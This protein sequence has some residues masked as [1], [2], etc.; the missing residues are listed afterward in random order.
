MT[1]LSSDEPEP[2]QKTLLLLLLDQ[3]LLPLHPLLH[4][5]PLLYGHVEFLQDQLLHHLGLDLR[6]PLHPHYDEMGAAHSLRPLRLLRPLF[7]LLPCP[8]QD[9]LRILL[10][11]LNL[12]PQSLHHHLLR[13]PSR[14]LLQFL[15]RS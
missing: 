14:P 5:R 7:L 10:L 12:A 1:S 9:Q 8:R 4:L 13:D 6:L 2:L 11:V 3:A 15:L